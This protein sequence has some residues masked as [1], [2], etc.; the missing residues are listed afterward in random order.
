M[1]TKATRLGAARGRI[2]RSGVQASPSSKAMQGDS[3]AISD[4]REKTE[5]VA[6]VFPT[7]AK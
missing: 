6:N 3:N 2:N 5:R 1:Q 4:N 7:P